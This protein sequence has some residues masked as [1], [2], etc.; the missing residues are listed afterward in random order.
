MTG[1][2]RIA[3]RQAALVL[4]L[5]L[6]AP[7]AAEPVLGVWQTGPDRKD[8]FAHVVVER[9]AQAICGT[10]AR[11]FDKDGREI[12]TPNVGKRVFWNLRPVGARR[13]EGRAYV[14][15]HDRTYDGELVLSG[16]R[17]TVK[18]CLGP[19]CMSQDWRRVR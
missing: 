7:A 14:P 3:G 11:A 5:L 15:A 2:A 12:T 17:L 9:C 16:D 8:Q 6:A 10:I 1:A 4:A 13:Y 19:L 18:G